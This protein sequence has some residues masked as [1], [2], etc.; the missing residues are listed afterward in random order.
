MSIEHVKYLIAEL[1]D[2]DAKF[3]RKA[4]NY[5]DGNQ[6]DELEDFL[7]D[8][9]GFRKNWKEKGLIPRSRNITKAIVDKSGLIFNGPTPK[10][11][12]WAGGSINETASATLSSLLDRANWIETFINFDNQVRLLKTGLMLVQWD[13]ERRRLILDALHQGNAVVTI[14]PNTKEITGLL[15]ALSIDEDGDEIFSYRHFTLE[16]ITDYSYVAESSE[17][18]VLG[19]FPNPYGIVPVAPF[20]DTSTPRY[21]IWNVIPDDLIGLNEM[22]NLHLMDSEYSASWSKVKTLFT[23]ATIGDSSMGTQTWVDPATGIPRQVPAAPN[24]VG[25]PGRIVEIDSGPASVYL[26]Y[27]GPDVTL[28]P[29]EEMFSQWVKDFAADWHVR[30]STSGNGGASSGFQLIVEEMPNLELRKQRQKMFAAGFAR[31]Y[32]VIASVVAGI[33][34]ISLPLDGELY[35]VFQNPAL[36]VD[37]KA[38]EE[39]WSRR[40]S[41]GR[42]S[43]VDYFMETQGMSREEAVAKVAEID[44]FNSAQPPAITRSSTVRVI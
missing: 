11:E 33:P 25:G 13:P 35:T 8:S 24:T 23:N 27:K 39:V 2:E 42:A 14:D 26:E 43:R 6:R 29:I 18:V 5:Y 31:L 28:M 36:P 22:Y 17:L 20:Y 32:K 30:L 12:V 44:A 7:K 4:L 21:G 41:E 3:A 40:I 1:G 34:G 15:V 38:L 37:D 16:T 19:S 10:L 9:S